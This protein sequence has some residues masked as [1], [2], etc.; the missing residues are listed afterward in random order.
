MKVLM[1]ATQLLT[2]MRFQDEGSVKEWLLFCKPLLDPTI[3][4]DIFKKLDQFN[5]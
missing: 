5:P 4:N 1:L 2:F 3:S